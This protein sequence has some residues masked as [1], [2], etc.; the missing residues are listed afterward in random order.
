MLR[1]KFG[2]LLLKMLPKLN[3]LTKNKEFDHVFKNGR[4]NYNKIIGIKTAPNNTDAIRLG[5]LV[6]NKVSKKST[7]RNKIKRKI[8]EIFR[9]KLGDLSAGNDYV[10]I[11]LPEALQGNFEDFEKAITLSLNK[12]KAF[13]KPNV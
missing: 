5:I 13:K 11:V 9:T 1:K 10:I 6:S 3:R 2:A 7:D 8:R 4:S 12:L